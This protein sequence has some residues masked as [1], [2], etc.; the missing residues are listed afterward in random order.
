MKKETR[1]QLILGIEDIK[2]MR[3]PFP[4]KILGFSIIFSII[5]IS[6]IL[7]FDNLQIINDWVPLILVVQTIIILIQLSILRNQA[8]YNKI[9]YI[10]EFY[11]LS[12]SIHSLTTPKDNGY[13]IILENYGD[14]AHRVNCKI[15]IGK[16]EKI[17]KKQFFEKIP[18]KGRETILEFLKLEKFTKQ[19]MRIY[20]SYFDKVGNH[21]FS[22]WF[23]DT[24][25]INFIA[26]LSGLEQ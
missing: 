18:R 15:T 12:E 19:Q 14:I 7:I 2:N 3:F 4:I 23:K 5:I 11:L 26:I 22:R 6:F 21:I 9:P 16:N 17:L 20:F 8:K 10:P 25:K 13:T 24:D 1:N